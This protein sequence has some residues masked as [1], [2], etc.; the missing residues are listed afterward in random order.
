MSDPAMAESTRIRIRANI[1]A[2]PLS[3]FRFMSISPFSFSSLHPSLVIGQNRA[4]YVERRR[5]NA[6]QIIESR[7]FVG[8]ENIPRRDVQQRLGFLLKDARLRILVRCLHREGNRH[9]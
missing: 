6:I 2:E 1:S 7:E 9:V 8:I 4:F 5:L 3:L